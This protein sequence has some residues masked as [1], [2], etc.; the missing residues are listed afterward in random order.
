MS[1][2]TAILNDAAA[3]R[4]LR[5]W[6]AQRLARCGSQYREEAL[7]ACTRISADVSGLSADAPSW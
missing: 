2:L 4:E 6:V 3:D 1:V 7:A 5:I